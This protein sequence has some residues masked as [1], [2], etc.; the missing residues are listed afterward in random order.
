MSEN[1]QNRRTTSHLVQTAIEGVQ[2]AGLPVAKVE[3]QGGG[4]VR[5]FVGQIGQLATTKEA[6]TCDKI[7]EE[8]S[9]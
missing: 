8:R 6:K 5:I 2:R 9:G 3:V 7:F 1:T 4:V